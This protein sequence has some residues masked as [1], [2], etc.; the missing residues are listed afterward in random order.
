VTFSG[1]FDVDDPFDV[2]RN[3]KITVERSDCRFGVLLS[4]PPS[5]SVL[6]S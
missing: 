5:F 3:A 4:A 1:F 2:E 6:S